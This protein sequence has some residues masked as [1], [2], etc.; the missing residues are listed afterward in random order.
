M[1]RRSRIG[2]DLLDESVCLDICIDRPPRADRDRQRA[3][4]SPLSGIIRDELPWRA[5]R[6]TGG[7][8]R[9]TDP[10][11]ERL[12]RGGGM[13]YVKGIS[14]L[15]VILGFFPVYMLAG[16][17]YVISETHIG[18]R[19]VSPVVPSLASNT[20]TTVTSLNPL[21]EWE[22]LPIGATQK[23]EVCI[24]DHSKAQR[25]TQSYGYN[26]GMGVNF[27][28]HPY[29]ETGGGS[30]STFGELVYCEKDISTSSHH[31]K[32]TLKPDTLYWWSVRIRVED[33]VSAWASRS[34]E[35]RSMNG[36]TNRQLSYSN[37]P[38]VFRT[39]KI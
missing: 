13:R 7:N 32:V 9:A 10:A 11:R 18:P 25:T 29:V 4:L 39:S 8:W 16:C 15:K 5:H 36:F 24:W 20:V 21:L 2:E 12:R 37:W 27:L 23:W 28:P 6:L 19:A 17:T 30:N 1:R 3:S 26:A 34:E 31:V 33:K 38:F 22:N 14:G 35:D